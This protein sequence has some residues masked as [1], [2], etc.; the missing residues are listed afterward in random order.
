MPRCST[1]LIGTALAGLATAM[2]PAA[3]DAQIQ[4]GRVCHEHAQLV[5][6]LADR[7]REVPVAI[8]L[9]T[10][11]QLVQ[12]FASSETGTWTI[13]VTRP[14]GTSCIL[15]AG[16]HYDQHELPPPGPGASADAEERAG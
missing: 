16:R 1:L 12:V 7:Y 5:K 3:A 13:L 14:G 11:G 6:A 8:G 2:L 4:G 10:D 9:Q 15:S